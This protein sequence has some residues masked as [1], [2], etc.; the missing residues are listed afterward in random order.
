QSVAGNL[1]SVDP[2]NGPALRLAADIDDV[3]VERHVATLALDR[4]L[5][6]LADADALELPRQVGQPAHRLAVDADDDVANRPAARIDTAQP[7]A[8]GRRAGYGAHDDHA[9][10]A[11][12]SRCILVGGNN[13]DAGRR[14][15]A[16]ADDLGHHPID[17]VDRDGEADA[18][19]GAG[20]REDRGVDADEA[21]GGVEQR[22]TGIARID[23][24]VG[25]D[26]VGDL[27]AVLGRPPAL[28][29]ADDAG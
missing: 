29:R 21:A 18:G 1:H 5:D 3:D 20:W 17:D 28:Q 26:H 14:H 25:L 2:G 8:I 13:A 22:P 24:G 23:G 19:A 6:L 4:E 16:F 7:G 11:G 9:L 27:A 12:P 15:V 10:D